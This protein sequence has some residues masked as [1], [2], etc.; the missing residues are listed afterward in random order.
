MEFE[1]IEARIKEGTIIAILDNKISSKEKGDIF[2]GGR[3]LVDKEQANEHWENI[4]KEVSKH[5]K[6]KI[7]DKYYEEIGRARKELII[8]ELLDNKG[9]N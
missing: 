6:T 8:G 3:W 2:F 7:I 1:H 4:V 5:Y 9:R